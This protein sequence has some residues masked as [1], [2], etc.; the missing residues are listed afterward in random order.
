MKWSQ[1]AY[2]KEQGLERYVLRRDDWE[3]DFEDDVEWYASVTH[4]DDGSWVAMIEPEDQE[5]SDESYD[6]Y[7]GTLEEAQKW[8]AVEMSLDG[9]I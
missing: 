2:D 5:R 8:A 7:F 6:Q 4:C 9:K 3:G 1:S